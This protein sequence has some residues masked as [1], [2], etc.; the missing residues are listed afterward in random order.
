MQTAI[1]CIQTTLFSLSSLFKYCRETISTLQT[2]SNKTK[3]HG[4]SPAPNPKT[5]ERHSIINFSP[6]QSHP[7]PSHLDNHLI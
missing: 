2:S 6:M 5:Q 1:H 4:N 3:Q 7:Q